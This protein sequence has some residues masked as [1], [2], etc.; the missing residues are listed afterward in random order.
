[1]TSV[2]AKLAGIANRAEAA[3]F[4]LRTLAG[5]LKEG[6]P[7]ESLSPGS[8]APGSA[9]VKENTRLT[10]YSSPGAARSQDLVHLQAMVTPD[11][12]NV[13]SVP[14]PITGEDP[15]SSLQNASPEGGAQ[16]EGDVPLQDAGV[17][18]GGVGASTVTIDADSVGSVR[19][20]KQLEPTQQAGMRLAT[21][22]GIVTTLAIVLII[23]DWIAKAP[24][25]GVPSGLAQMDPTQAKAVMENLKTLNEVSVDSAVKMFDTI[26]ARSLL[27]VFTAILGYIFGTRASRNDTGK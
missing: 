15:T 26:V 19:L 23:A 2:R 10:D 1:M 7:A 22:V 13:G 20:N 11:E 24:W 12:P 27:P 9:Q 14:N 25:L 5:V 4:P 17:P 8:S 16:R 18:P 6:R 21:G 3:T